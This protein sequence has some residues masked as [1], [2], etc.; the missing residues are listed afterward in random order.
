MTGGLRLECLGLD[1]PLSDLVGES[2]RSALA[3]LGLSGALDRLVICADDLAGCDDAWVQPGRGARR[4]DLTLYCHPEVFLAARAA[5]GVPAA[6][7]DCPGPGDTSRPPVSASAF[8]RVRT[9]AFLHHHLTVIGD[10][11]RGELDPSTVPADLAEAFDA[12]WAIG[13]DGRLGRAGLPGYP[14]AERRRR[15]SRLFSQAGILMPAHWTVFQ[16]L[17]DGVAAGQ[18]DVVRLARALPRL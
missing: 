7:W 5:P 16:E 15:F 8:S 11:M 18:Q 12:A 3:A 10:L 1:A 2:A 13:V 9:E 4:R 6:V 17:W 14:L